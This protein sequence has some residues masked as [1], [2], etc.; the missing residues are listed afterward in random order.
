MNKIMNLNTAQNDCVKTTLH[1]AIHRFL[2]GR[3]KLG[4]RIKTFV[5][6]LAIP[7]GFGKTRIAIQGIFNYTENKKNI[8][9][10]VILWPQK[11]AHITDIWVK[12]KNWEKKASDGNDEPY[13]KIHW[14][15]LI[16]ENKNAGK[17][18]N[19][20]KNVLCT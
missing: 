7:T 8:E 18:Y 19:G 17:K 3:N 9:G 16:E 6:P 1:Q 2:Y 14:R 15:R 11:K 13:Q 4:R 12:S 5:L 20:K 10:T